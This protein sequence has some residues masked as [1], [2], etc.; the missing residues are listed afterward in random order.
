MAK[1]LVR[2]DPTTFSKVIGEAVVP[3]LREI[4]RDLG[5]GLPTSVV[6]WMP[7]MEGPRV[8]LVPPTAQGA[9]AAAK[10]LGEMRLS[11]RATAVPGRYLFFGEAIYERDVAPGKPFSGFDIQGVV[12]R[13]GDE[14]KVKEDIRTIKFQEWQF[15]GWK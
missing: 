2:P 4:E 3:A 7:H 5:R 11:F 10:P 8:L 6:L 9:A 1:E 12:W 14:L 13:E 15:A